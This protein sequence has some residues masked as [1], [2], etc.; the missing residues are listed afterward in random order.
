[1]TIIYAVSGIAINHRADWNPNYIVDTKY[2]ETA[3]NFSQDDLTIS[4]VKA[5]LDKN[6]EIYRKHYFP[7]ATTLKVFIK[8]GLM[9]L[10][11]ESGRGYIEKTT[12]RPILG[13][14]NYLHYNPVYYWTI[15]SDIFCI[16]LFLISISGL[17][18]IRGKKGITGRGAWLTGVG[19]LIPIIY[20]F[21]YYY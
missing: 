3:G 19:I 4:A 1:M 6:D 7:D 5:I 9:S 13:P 15:F 2:I 18:I 20:L 21:V 11:M 17:F 12:K 10:D 16:A 8:G 14:M